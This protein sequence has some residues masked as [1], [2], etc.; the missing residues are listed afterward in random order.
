MGLT[1]PGG[2]WGAGSPH[3]PGYL[4]CCSSPSSPPSPRGPLSLGGPPSSEG[5]PSSGGPPLSGGPLF[6]SGGLSLSGGL[7]SQFEYTLLEYPLSQ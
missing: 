5:S 6:P 4:G 7:P 2:P 1:G 3:P